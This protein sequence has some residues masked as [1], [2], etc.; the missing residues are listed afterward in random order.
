MAVTKQKGEVAEAF[1]TYFLKKHGFNVLIPWGEDTRYDLVIEKNG[2]FK[3]VQVK[4][5]TPKNGVL[6]IPIRSSNNHSIIHYSEKD[7]DIIAAYSP[8]S[9]KVYL[10]PLKNIRNRRAVKLRLE[11]ARNKQKKYVTM[12]TCYE[13]RVDFLER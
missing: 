2:V 12:A 3:R 10:I 5:I 13:S 4:Y 8:E 9:Q 1:V 7:I 6:E 11:P